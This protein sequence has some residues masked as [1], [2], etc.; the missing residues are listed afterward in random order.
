MSNELLRQIKSIDYLLDLPTSQKLIAISSRDFVRDVLRILL[1]DLRKEILDNQLP[2]DSNLIEIIENELPVYWQSLTNN[3]L[4]PVINATGTLLHTNL[5]RSPLAIEALEEINKIAS[6]YCNLEYD[7]AAGKRGHRDQ[8]CEELLKT[9]LGCEAAVVV[10]NNAAAVM[11]VLDELASGGEAIISRGELIEI[12]GAFRIPDVMKKSGTVL[13][14]VG[15]TNRTRLSD[16]ETAINENTKVI[17]RVHPSNYRITGFTEK[18]SLSELVKLSEKH[19][20]V[21]IEDL[22]SGCLV[23]LTPYGVKDEPTAQAS[24]AAGVHVITFSGDKM[25]GGPQAGII[26]GK[27]AYISRIRRNPLLRALRVDKLCYGALAATLRL[28]QFGTAWEKIPLL[29]ALKATDKEIM[30]RSKN[31]LRRVKRKLSTNTTLS[32]DLQSGGSLMGAGSAPEVLLPTTLIAIKDTKLSSL[33]LANKLRASKTPVIAR[34][35]EDKLLLDLRSV[36]PRD[37]PLLEEI[38]VNLR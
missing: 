7:L 9:L 30:T 20:L 11:L 14:E 36:L 35:E 18:P 31:F 5:G 34:I 8:H 22:G 3:S 16:Y 4:Q 28:Y 13:R 37:E 27:K 15:T 38:I 24:I 23:D 29:Q 33:D 12:G 17:L 26:A 10:N 21:L 25:L 19:N 2:Q 1:T 32:F 6:S